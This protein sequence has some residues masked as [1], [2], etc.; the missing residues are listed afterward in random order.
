[1]TV[2]RIFPLLLLTGLLLF[3]GC[4][5]NGN[6]GT[7]TGGTKTDSKWACAN[8]TPQTGDWV[9]MHILSNPDMLTPFLSQTSDANTIMGYIFPSLLDLDPYT[10]EIVPLLVKSRPTF[11]EEGT[12]Y[13][14]EIR[15]EAVWDNGDPVTGEDYS[16]TLKVIKNP[17]VNCP[18]QR[19]YV[20]FIEDVII[21]PENPKK[22]SVKVNSKYFRTET[23]LGFL[24]TVPRH[25]Y[26]PENLMEKFTI[27]E[28]NKNADA[29]RSNPDIIKFAE[30]YNGEKF[31]RE[32]VE[33]C[34]AWELDEWVT[35]QKVSLSR[36]QNW[37]GDKF[38]D[39]GES[40]SL[41]NYPDKMVF[42]IINDRTTAIIALKNKEIDVMDRI[43]AQDFVEIKDNPLVTDDF[44]L[45]TPELLGYG[46]IALNNRP[47]K[48]HKPFFVDKRVRRAMAHLINSQSIIDNVYYG[49]GQPTA[50]PISISRPEYNQ[51]LKPIEHNLE[52]AKQLLDEAGWKDSNGNG[53]RDKMI[54]GELV[55]FEF[56][57][58]YNQGNDERK[59]VALIFQKE[60]AKVGVVATPVVYEWSNFLERHTQHDF[61]AFVA[62]LQNPP[63]PPD[64]KQ[65][66][67][68]ESWANNGTNYWGFGTPESD[69]LIEA[70]R[71]D[72]NDETRIA[73]TKRVQEI[74]YE[75]QPVVFYYS[76]M[77]KIAIHKRFR[78]TKTS[79]VRP[80]YYPNRF[81]TCPELMLYTETTQ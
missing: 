68:T 60:C 56:D 10:Q 5:G 3:V 7:D 41:V 36:K 4:N 6:D 9:I 55:E 18:Q 78:N 47:P 48:D 70:I 58:E 77:N 39:S 38:R 67:H 22:F 81:W 32:V 19:V 24:Y 62:A 28:L 44:E 40:F 45:S 46:F 8:E 2:K 29:L 25:I 30:Q 21:D 50:S 14:F 64:M 57:V 17:L 59:K 63:L 43:R 31:Q 73:K 12:E 75:E 20:E 42:K 27:A 61:D 26:D 33:G 13:Y 71:L 49:Y 37:W 11:N 1:M 16:F 53:T 34:G 76:P 23:S 65:A 74:I 52:M 35:G 66:W 15:E 69:S 51:N 72:L 80:G 79:G 54:D